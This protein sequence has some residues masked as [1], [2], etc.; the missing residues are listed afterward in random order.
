MLDREAYGLAGRLADPAN[1]EQQDHGGDRYEDVVEPGEQPELF[2]IGNG[3]TPAFDISAQRVGGFGGERA[4]GNRVVEL[5]L[6]VH[7]DFPPCAPAKL[8]PSVLFSQYS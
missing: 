2:L 7:V 6:A 8:R 3:R 1:R 5:L 4:R